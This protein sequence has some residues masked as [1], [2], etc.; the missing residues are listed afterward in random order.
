MLK[1]LGVFRR[2]EDIGL[3]LSRI[4]EFV[5][6][7]EEQR[8]IMV[9]LAG[10]T[11]A[12]ATQAASPVL[13]QAGSGQLE[14]AGEAVGPPDDT[15]GASGDEDQSTDPVAPETGV[16]PH[17]AAPEEAPLSEDGPAGA[18]PEEAADLQLAYRGILT[19]LEHAFPGSRLEQIPEGDF[20]S[21]FWFHA[22]VFAR[23]EVRSPLISRRQDFTD[24]LWKVSRNDPLA[25][26]FVLYEIVRHMLESINGDAIGQL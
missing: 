6:L 13:G 1:L 22:R 18:G 17:A 19:I 2:Y 5:G 9:P 25:P 3:L 11:P 26:V 4:Y 20:S 16:E 21:L 12:A 14:S 10:R 15:A 24:L 8:I 7:G 23:R